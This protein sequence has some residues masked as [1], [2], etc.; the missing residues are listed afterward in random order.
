MVTPAIISSAVDPPLNHTIPISPDIDTM[1]ML[2]CSVVWCV[3]VGAYPPTPSVHLK[4]QT[5]P[6]RQK[7]IADCSEI[8]RKIYAIANLPFCQPAP[9]ILP[10]LRAG[11]S[12][13]KIPALRDGNTTSQ[14]FRR[15]AP[16]IPLLKIPALCAGNTL[17]KIARRLAPKIAP[18]IPP[19]LRA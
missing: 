13:P 12:A 4:T 18:N 1:F 14:I 17:A 11:N 9:S 19:P 2:C 5:L 10:A 6:G 8:P 3:C 15:F 7:K 16:E